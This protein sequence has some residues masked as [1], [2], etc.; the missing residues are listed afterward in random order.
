[1]ALPT[2]RKVWRLALP[3]GTHLVSGRP[4]LGRAVLWARRMAVHPP[5]FGALEQGD[6]ALLSMEALALLDERLTLIRVVAALASRGASAVGVVGS[7]PPTAIQASNDHELAL[8]SLPHGT[9]LRD[10]ERDIIRL[11]VEHEAQVDRRRQEIHQQLTHISIENGGLPAIAEGLL[12]ITG[13]PAV[14]Q[15]GQ[16]AIK[17]LSWPSERTDNPQPLLDTLV[18]SDLPHD[19]SWSGRTNGGRPPLSSA[20]VSGSAWTRHT[21]VVA[22]EGKLVGYLSLLSQ[23]GVDDLDQ[24]ALDQ[25]AMVCAVEIAKQR[26]VAAAEDRMRGDFLDALLTADNAREPALARRAVQLGYAI[27]GFHG[28][29]LFRVDPHS[30]QILALLASEFR[31]LLLDTGIRTFICPHEGNLVAL[32]NADDPVALRRLEGIAQEARQRTRERLT[33]G[34]GPPKVAIGIGRPAAG[35]AGLRASLAQAE[36]AVA[37]ASELFGG[38][39]VLTFTD[40]GVYSILFRLQGA[41]ELHEF[42]SRTLGPLVRYDASHNTQLVETLDAFFANLGNVSQTAE[43]LFLHRNS[44]LY[45]LERIGD[46]TDLD[47]NDPDDRFSLQLA[48]RMRPFVASSRLPD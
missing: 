6:M 14:V 35:L 12:T 46:I 19:Q 23:E 24:L 40:L 34:D 45:R 32:C 27:D 38:D 20:P 13:K 5:A 18:D 4:G 16:G 43:S 28:A 42:Y 30:A 3:T 2:V 11:I 25:G 41:D 9:D 48:L 31:T 26:A 47:L 37:L 8:F 44:L 22:I 33:S 39:R 17:A 10:I 15:D 21:A 7:P 29:M 36:E 1:M